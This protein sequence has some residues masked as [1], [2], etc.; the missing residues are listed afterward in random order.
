MK[1]ILQ[2]ENALNYP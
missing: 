1:V 2:T